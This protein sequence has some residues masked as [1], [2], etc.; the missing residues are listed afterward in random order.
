VRRAVALFASAALAI[1]ATAC[2]SS[3]PCGSDPGIHVRVIMPDST[4][5][6]RTNQVSITAREEPPTGDGCAALWT[7][8]MPG[9][10]ERMINGARD[11]W[12]QGLY[13]NIQ[14]A[15]YP[16]LSIFAYAY[17]SPDSGVDAALAGGCVDYRSTPPVECI[18]LPL[19]AKQ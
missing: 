11:E 5:D 2:S 19:S 4:T 15:D 18:T 13:L 10:K 14:L 3:G 7:T 17:A 6:G 9:L 16:M 12:A 1:A 8:P